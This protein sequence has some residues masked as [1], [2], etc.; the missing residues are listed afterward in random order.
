MESLYSKQRKRKKEEESKNLLEGDLS[1]VGWIYANFSIF[2]MTTILNALIFLSILGLLCFDCYESSIYSLRSE[3]DF[4][5]GTQRSS[6]QS[7]KNRGKQME[8]TSS[9]PRRLNVNLK[10]LPPIN[11]PRI[12]NGNQFSIP[13][14]FDW[15]PAIV[16]HVLWI[17]KGL[18]FL[19]G[20]VS[21]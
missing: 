4:W 13:V 17:S 14:K 21:G 8:N 18:W 7:G 5:Y 20:L 16:F 10:N 6:K 1:R 15:F 19:S 9:C 11:N 2:R 3:I 12:G